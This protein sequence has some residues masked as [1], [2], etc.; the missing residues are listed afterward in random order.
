MREH[1]GLHRGQRIDKGE[2]VEGS[3][4]KVTLNGKTA[5]LIF[6]DNFRFIGNDVRALSHALVDPD[7]VGECTGLRDKN[8]KLVF[9]GDILRIAQ[10]G[11]GLGD[12]YFPPVEYPVKVVVR[13]DMCAW[14]W[15]TLC[16]DKRF[17]GFP[18]AW[19][20]YECEII[21]NIHDDPEL[22]KGG[23]GDG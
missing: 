20:H 17:I 11:N 3:L 4:L 12:Y 15:E 19:C 13:W 2:W 10:K 6:G 21:G 23:E 14:M 1:M 9:E 16:E 5:Y 22:L 8:G 18:S 7:T